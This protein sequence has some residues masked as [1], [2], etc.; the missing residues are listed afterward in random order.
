MPPRADAFDAQEEATKPAANNFLQ[1]Q[2]K[3]DDFLECY[4]QD[5]PHQALDMKYPAELYQRSPRATRALA[6]SSTPFTT[7]P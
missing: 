4:D 1:Q 5:R 6:S 3:F 2:A 7:D